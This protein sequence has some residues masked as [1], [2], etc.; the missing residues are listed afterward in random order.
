MQVEQLN[1]N[2][3]ERVKKDGM[4]HGLKV[5]IDKI[6]KAQRYNRRPWDTSS[7][8]KRVTIYFTWVTNS[9]G[10]Q[11]N[12]ENNMLMAHI[13]TTKND[14]PTL[15]RLVIPEAGHKLF[16]GE[17]GYPSSGLRAGLFSILEAMVEQAQKHITINN[18]QEIIRSELIS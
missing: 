13:I 3:L 16:C 6:E 7:K 11:P 1:K 17:Y 15:E 9:N 8:R 5:L 12:H 14:N 18:W 2:R 4:S 10:F